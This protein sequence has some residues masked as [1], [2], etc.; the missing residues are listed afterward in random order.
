MRQLG[1]QTQDRMLGPLRAEERRLRKWSTKRRELL[2]DRIEELPEN[3]RKARQYKQQLQEMDAYL[4]DRT[5]NW[6]NSYFTTTT[7]P[8]T[9]LVL[10]IEGVR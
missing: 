7:E 6:V 5:E 2:E 9:Q 4:K 3:H 10:V 1:V 8:S